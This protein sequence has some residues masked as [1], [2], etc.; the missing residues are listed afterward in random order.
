MWLFRFRKSVV[1]KCQIV[2]WPQLVEFCP[3]FLGADGI[4]AGQEVTIRYGTWPAEP[5]LL[6][7]GFVPQPNPHDSITLFSNLQHMA[8]CYL[9]CL[10]SQ[11]KQLS[12]LEQAT[13]SANAGSRQLQVADGQ[14]ATQPTAAAVMHKAQQLVQDQE[15]GRVF[16][17]E[18]LAAEHQQQQLSE[19]AVDGG[20]DVGPFKGPGGFVDLIINLQGIDG[21]LPA[22]LSIIY[23]AVSIAVQQC[24]GDQQ[25]SMPADP[26]AAAGPS[27]GSSNRC[28]SSGNSSDSSSTFSTEEA[29][30]HPPAVPNTLAQK[31]AMSSSNSIPDEV[32]SVLQLPLTC[33]IANRLRHLQSQLADRG[34]Q[35]DSACSNQGSPA[36]AASAANNAFFDSQHRY[37]PDAE[38]AKLI[39]SYRSS[40]GALVQQ[41]LAKHFST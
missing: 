29:D 4:K 39:S 16:H 5:F 41:L 18:V 23:R 30:N 6:L 27:E 38:H 14:Q 26:V 25:T 9:Q 33:V 8:E 24:C 20:A 22:A 7:F 40:K 36:K 31:A 15:F 35:G 1:W 12:L 2:V 21:R 19:H 37:S 11:V 17:R 32:T 34:A 28:V 13:D 3:L 10:A